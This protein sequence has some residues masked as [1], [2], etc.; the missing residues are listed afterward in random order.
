MQSVFKIVQQ[1]RKWL[2]ISVAMKNIQDTYVNLG[3]QKL[4]MGVS[5]LQR[6]QNKDRCNILNTKLTI[7][8]F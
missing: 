3:L 5:W 8:Y 7:T 2:P 6:K 1:D 4:D